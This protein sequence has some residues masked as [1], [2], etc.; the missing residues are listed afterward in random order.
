MIGDDEFGRFEGQTPRKETVLDKGVSTV[1]LTIALNAIRNNLFK[2]VPSIPV[3]A[4]PD[5]PN[6]HVPENESE[7]A[8]TPIIVVPTTVVPI[9]V[10][11]NVISGPITF[12]KKHNSFTPNKASILLE[13]TKD[14][15]YMNVSSN[16]KGKLHG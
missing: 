14:F 8:T 16:N 9:E 12:L 5:S 4:Q 10:V 11:D 15:K 7:T 3:A 13:S 6:H 2:D 1:P